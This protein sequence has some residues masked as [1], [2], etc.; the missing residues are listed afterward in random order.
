M[1]RIKILLILITLLIIPTK[2]LALNEVNVYLFYSDSCDICSQ[3]KVYL[4]ALKERYPNMRIYYYETNSEDNYN[5]M[6]KAKS[7]YNQNGSGVPF[8]VIG[9]KAYLGFAQNKKALFQ[10]TVYNYS[11]TTYDN[12]LGKEL[13][14]TYRTDLSGTVKEYK[15]NANYQIEETSGIK[16]NN[17]V[18][19]TNNKYDKYKVSFYLVGVGVILAVIAIILYIRERK[20]GK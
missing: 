8:T 19:K 10:Q 1:K 16:Q 3:E 11:T 13:G 18:N 14:I 17:N 12:K 2:A 4:N 6:L 5:L 9:D 20:T 7:L 15:D